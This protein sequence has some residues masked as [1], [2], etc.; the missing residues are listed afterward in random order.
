MASGSKPNRCANAVTYRGGDHDEHVGMRRPSAGPSSWM[1][2]ERGGARHRAPCATC[3]TPVRAGPPWTRPMSRQS[4][5]G[6][7]TA[8][9]SARPEADRPITGT[10]PNEERRFP[11]GPWRSRAATS[12]AYA[13][14][15]SS[16]ARTAQPPAAPVPPPWLPQQRSMTESREPWSPIGPAVSNGCQT[17]GLMLACVR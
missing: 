9:T 4:A 3:R 15:W 8:A 10:E 5:D 13:C 6:S 7:P 16:S 1:I 2:S 14:R 11:A 17:A 12:K